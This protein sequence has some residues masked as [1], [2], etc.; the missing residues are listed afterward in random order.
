MSQKMS[1]FDVEK[2]TMT[3]AEE[4]EREILISTLDGEKRMR[5]AAEQQLQAKDSRISILEER[6]ATKIEENSIALKQLTQF[7]LGN[8]PVTISGTLKDAITA[9]LRE[10]FEKQKQELIA[11]YEKLL[12]DLKRQL[13]DKDAQ[14]AAYKTEN[15]RLRSGDHRSGGDIPGMP[16]TSSMTQ[17]EVDALMQQNNNLASSLF[18]QHTETDKYRHGQQQ[19]EDA[20]TLDMN[21]EDVPVETV[22]VIA[23]QIKAGRNTSKG[24][25]KPRRS[26]PLKDMA[27]QDGNRIIVRP[28]NVP[29]DAEP[30]GSEKRYRTEFVRGYTRM[31]CIELLKFRGKDGTIYEAHLPKKYRNCMGRT[32]AT[33]SI[34]AQ[35]LV[36]HY[37]GGM[38]IGDILNWLK[39]QGLNFAKS[40]IENWIAIGADMLAPTDEVLHEAITSVE[41]THSDET[42]CKM[43][44]KR[45]PDTA[46]GETD[47]DVEENLKYFKRWMFSIYAPE[48]KLTQFFFYKRGRRSREAIVE[49]LKNVRH[50]LYLHTDGAPMY[51]CFEKDR[52]TDGSKGDLI[53]ELIVRIACLVHVRRPFYKLKDVYE[54]ARRIVDLINRIFHEDKLIKARCSTPDEVKH[55]RLLTIAP[56]LNDLKNELETLLPRLEQDEDA[57][58]M[59]KAVR[60]A[61]KEF[62]CLLNS[63]KDGRL[64]LDNNSCERTIRSI[65]KYRNNSFFVGSP[66]GGVRLARMKSIFANCRAY[67]LNAYEYL[68]DVFRRIGTTAHEDLINLLP[69]K[70]QL[71]TVSQY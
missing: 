60:Y 20:D 14:L 12:A 45:L 26:Q 38:T 30:F 67:G 40:T 69:H 33:E 4:R 46:N 54:D 24:K 15:E 7:M 18:G 52:E 50:R 56:L 51:K 2:E 49:Y 31:I 17:G 6:L 35:I 34:I 68:C 36:M 37:D 22:K 44:D 3:K 61:L 42:T 5:L 55:E 59:L 32:T 65:T 21:G 8:G 71:A 41:V 23:G 10:E 11:A 29:V 47:D 64:S 43:C 16:P 1:T 53:Y 63:L 57:P 13:V 27:E 25:D 19:T 28:D 62:P 39:E 58:E 70:W 9:G 48:L 66:V